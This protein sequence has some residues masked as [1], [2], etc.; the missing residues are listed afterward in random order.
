MHTSG[1]YIAVFTLKRRRS[2]TVGRLG[3]FTFEP[4]WYF[5]VGS[6][7]RGLESRLTRHARPDKTQHWHID[8]LAAKAQFACALTLPAGREAECRLARRIARRYAGPVAG[9]GASDCNCR[10]HLFYRPFAGAG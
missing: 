9:F 4:G 2:I 7:Q 6:A 1:I 8:Y 10:T 5:Y 3:P